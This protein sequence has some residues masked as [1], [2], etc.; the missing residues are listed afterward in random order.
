MVKALM[1][2]TLKTIDAHPSHPLFAGPTLSIPPRDYGHII[3]AAMPKH[4][5]NMI[6][7]TFELWRA[8]FHLLWYF[9]DCSYDMKAFHEML[10]LHGTPKDGGNV[11]LDKMNIRGEI[12]G[13][14][15]QQQK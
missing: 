12:S 9:I 1:P 4:L 15:L 10:K 6:A 13:E 11:L 14:K 5:A 7:N 8:S 2:P 3:I